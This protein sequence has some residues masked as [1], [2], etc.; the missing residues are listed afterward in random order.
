MTDNA[1]SHW[2]RMRRLITDAETL[3]RNEFPSAGDSLMALYVHDALASKAAVLEAELER[4]KEQVR[5]MA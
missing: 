3:V 1:E 4:L 5:T 2:D